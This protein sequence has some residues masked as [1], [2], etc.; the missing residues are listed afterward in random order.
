MNSV[1]ISAVTAGYDRTP[2]LDHVSLTV[3]AGG[4]IAILGASGGGKTPG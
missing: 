2:V 3:P 4:T 1:Q